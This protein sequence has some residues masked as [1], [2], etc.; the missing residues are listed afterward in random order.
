MKYFGCFILVGFVDFQP[1]WNVLKWGPS[2]FCKSGSKDLRCAPQAFFVSNKMLFFSSSRSFCVVS[3]GTET[4][5]QMSFSHF[6][7]HHFVSWPMTKGK[8]HRQKPYNFWKFSV[9]ILFL[10]L[11][12]LISF[13]YE[14]VVGKS[15]NRP[16]KG[17]FL[18][19]FLNFR[20][21]VFYDVVS[22]RVYCSFVSLLTLMSKVLGSF[23]RVTLRSHSHNTIVERRAILHFKSFYLDFRV[24]SSVDLKVHQAENQQKVALRASHLQ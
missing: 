3:S 20:W 13:D 9:I 22:V 6:L 7:R 4:S 10:K 12:F 5:L 15:G 14:I 16:P 18:N 11:F 1:L 23:R 8:S 2:S 21:T 24:Y 19:V 17:I